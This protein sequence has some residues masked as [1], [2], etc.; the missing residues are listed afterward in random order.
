MDRSEAA[1][2]AAAL[3]RDAIVIDG[4]S[5]ILMAIADRKM[6]LGDRVELPLHE[7]WQPPL[8]W[9]EPAESKLYDFSPHTAYFQT[10]GQY[11]IPRF[12][13]GG[14]TAQACAIYLED[15]H[16]DRPL[17]RA[18]E[19][20][21]WLNREAEDNPDFELITTVDGFQQVKQADKTGGFLTF[22]GFEPLESDLK[23]LDVFYDL[24]LRMASLTHSR[25]N[26]F[27]DGTQMGVRGGG[28]TK[29][30]QDAV[31]RMNELGILIDLAHLNPAGCWEVIERSEAP[32]VLSHTSPHRYFPEDASGSPLY[33]DIVDD[34]SRDLL[35]AIAGTGGLVGIIAYSQPDVD[36]YIDDIDYVIRAVG[37]DHIALGTDFFGMER[38]PKGFTTMAELPNLTA[39]LVE[40]GYSDDVI[41]KFLGENYLR[42]FS[43]VWK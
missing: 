20:V 16:L 27:A 26:I 38:A 29:Q 15:T 9:T 25:R 35:D 43:H 28:L 42:V 7:G 23:L 30:G 33:P 10:M 5:D 37:P 36:A 6:R 40:R 11:D 31:R 3:H 4:H 8:G 18:L 12:L 1:S 22:E 19:M 34:R 39:R 32:V 13:E 24:G 17:H 14:L 21:Y 2:H 41:R